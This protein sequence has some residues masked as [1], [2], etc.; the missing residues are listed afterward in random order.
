[1]PSHTHRVDPQTW[2]STRHYDN[3]RR[4]TR[5]CWHF[6]D[7]RDPRPATAKEMHTIRP[8]QD[9]GPTVEDQARTKPVLTVTCPRCFTQ[10]TVSGACAC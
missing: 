8:C 4:H 3:R 6:T 1:M 10:V 9:C 7:T 5:D 2:V